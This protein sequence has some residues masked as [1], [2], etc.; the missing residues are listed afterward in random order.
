MHLR[1]YS[2]SD[3]VSKVLDLGNLSSLMQDMKQ[4]Q[5][6]KYSEELGVI[7]ADFG[8]SN[9]SILASG[10][11]ILKEVNNESQAQEIFETLSPLLQKSLIF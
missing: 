3:P 7:K 4:V 11:V 1:V 8:H 10:R 6:L 9:I 5:N 2:G